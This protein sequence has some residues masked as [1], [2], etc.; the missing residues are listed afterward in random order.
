MEHKQI[1]KARAARTSGRD[2]AKIKP[3]KPIQA[4]SDDERFDFHAA[5]CVESYGAHD[6]CVFTLQRKSHG[7]DGA[8]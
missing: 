5:C 2:S 1:P 4:I 7:M 3:Y 8:A 6:S